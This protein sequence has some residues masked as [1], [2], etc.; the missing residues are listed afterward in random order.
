[1]TTGLIIGKF[2]PPHAGHHYLIEEARKRCDHLD[3]LVWWSEVESIPGWTRAK[4]LQEIHDVIPP[5]KG[6]PPVAI[7]D[8]Q[9]EIVPDYDDSDVWWQHMNL[10]WKQFPGKHDQLNQGYPAWDYVFTSEDYGDELARRVGAQ[11]ICIDPQRTNVPISGTA[12][13]NDPAANWQHLAE[14]T[15]ALLT[16]RFL[17]TGAESTGTTTLTRAL[18]QHY[19]TVWVPEYGRFYTEGSGLLNHQWTTDE[20]LH[21]VEGQHLAE[22]FLARK[23]GPVMFCDTDALS[24]KVWHERY[25]WK[26]DPIFDQ[27]FR[28]YEHVF[29]TDYMEVP[30]EDDGLRD[31]SLEIRQWMQE[32][33]LQEAIEFYPHSR[34]NIMIGGPRLRMAHAIHTVDKYLIDGWYL[35]PPLGQE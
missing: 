33:L 34:V 3:V 20:F 35:N 17:V 6:K 2:Y 21:I 7:Y 19:D 22:D 13:R 12:I 24:T 27:H 28:K 15:R 14:P 9:C 30:L 16:K 4:L 26:N 18:A 29:I 10:L 31:G 32:R 1:M 5:Y 25:T 8:Q 11:H 23:A